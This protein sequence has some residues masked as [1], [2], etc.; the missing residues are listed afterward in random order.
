MRN[1]SLVSF[2]K[3]GGRGSRTV[4][5]SWLKGH[6]MQDDS[7]PRHKEKKVC[8]GRRRKWHG[9]RAGAMSEGLHCI[10]KAWSIL[11]SSWQSWV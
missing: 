2:G 5:R 9:L 4:F 6:K 8:G 7:A 11:A 10:S 1:K 3:G